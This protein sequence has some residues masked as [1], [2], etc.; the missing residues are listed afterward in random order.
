MNRKEECPKGYKNTVINSFLI[1]A[2]TIYSTEKQFHNEIYY[3]KKMLI[4]NSYSPKLIQES[5]EK[6]LLYRNGAK[7]KRHKTIL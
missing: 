4:F 6:F 2:N 7:L 5:T 3:I 1:R